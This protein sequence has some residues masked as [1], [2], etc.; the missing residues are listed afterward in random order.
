MG[1]SEFVAPMQHLSGS[2]AV[3]EVLVVS[4]GVSG[5]MIGPPSAVDERW[6]MMEGSLPS[7]ITYP[8]PGRG[9]RMICIQQSKAKQD[10]RSAKGGTGGWYWRVVLEGGTGG[11][12]RKCKSDYS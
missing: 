6:R 2:Q 3:A 5:Q 12:R 10:G 8:A 4:H 11:V 1:C 7:R 9:S